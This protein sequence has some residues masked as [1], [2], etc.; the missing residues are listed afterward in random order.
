MKL[1]R[2]LAV[3]AETDDPVRE[4]RFDTFRWSLAMGW[5]GRAQRLICWK[6]RRRRYGENL[7]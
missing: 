2:L 7:P 6:K 4:L 1:A 3:F 5:P